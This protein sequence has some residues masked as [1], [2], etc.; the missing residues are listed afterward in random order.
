MI[1][2]V[3]STLVLL[4][5]LD[6]GLAAAANRLRATLAPAAMPLLPAHCTLFGHLPGPSAPQLAADLR[7]LV[8]AHR[9]PVMRLLPPRRYDRSIAIPVQSD[10]LSAL[11]AILAHWWG[12]MLQPNERA[13]PRLHITLATGLDR[14][15][16]ATA[17][18]QAISALRKAPF[19]DCPLRCRALSLQP[20]MSPGAAPLLRAVFPG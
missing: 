18:E 15:A 19:M 10:E 8:R 6:P 17:L 9:A 4:A 3:P 11:H 1:Q 7:S 5:A 12:P 16:A 14:A 2:A 13:P 20:R